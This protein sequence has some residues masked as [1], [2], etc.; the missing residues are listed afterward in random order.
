MSLFKHIPMILFFV[1]IFSSCVSSGS[2]NHHNHSQSLSSNHSRKVEYSGLCADA[3]SKGITNHIGSDQIRYYDKNTKKTYYFASQRA[4][5]SFLSNVSK[6]SKLA[7]RTW[8]K[9]FFHPSDI[10]NEFK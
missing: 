9:N 7:D 5:R 10:K 6:N 3:L 8:R 2:A 1:L 4:K